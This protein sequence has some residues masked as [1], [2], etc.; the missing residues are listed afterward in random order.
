M[1]GFFKSVLATVVGL[2]LFFIIM[3]FFLVISMVGMIASGEQTKS[4]RDNSVLVL[5]LTGVMEERAENDF[6]SQL[7]GNFS[8]Q[9][10]LDDILSAIKK[11]KD[12][13][14]I[15]GIYIEAGAFA[16]DSYASMQAIRRAL[17]DFKKSGK[18]IVAYADTYTQGT[19]YLA[20]AADKVWL[21]PQGMLDWHGLAAQKV[22]FKDVLAKVGV[23]MQIAKVGSYKSAVE[24]FTGDKMSDADRE[25][26]EAYIN[27]IWQNVTKDVAAS[28][29][30]SVEQL[31]AYADSLIT[32]N[33]TKDMLKLKLVDALLYTD[34]VKTEVKKLLKIENDERI[35]QLSINDMKNVKGKSKEGE[36]IAVYYAYGDIVDGAAGGGFGNQEHQID[37]QVVCKDLQKLMDDD[38]VKAVVMRIN[39][40]G[41]S[42]YASEQI[43]HALMEMK[44]KKPVVVSMGGMAASGGYYISAPANWI[45]A[46]PTTLTGS[47]GI[48]GMFPDASELLTQK[49]GLKYDEVKTNKFSTFGAQNRPIS[50]EEMAYLEAYI[51][52]GYQL[53][54]QRVAQGRKMTTDQV[55]KIA[56]G[57]VWIGQDALGIKLVD[58]LGGLDA[59]V[60]KAASLAKLQEY[61]TNSY[62]APADWMDQLLNET[63]GGNYLDEELQAT[64]GEYYQPIMLMK[65]IRQMNPIQTRLP[66]YIYIR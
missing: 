1:K 8:G 66:Y 17:T 39:S 23:K 15:K 33:D 45:V 36:E 41:G 60:A 56:Q 59:A 35:H 11:A 25:Q 18:W 49:I 64:L 13:E 7:T 14:K 24:I 22:Y 12:N 34:Q 63:K 53:F 10:G 3:G 51:E 48:F 46:E 6:M 5:N 4:V 58:Q 26:T 42:A 47:I 2:F 29:K 21:N 9:L 27:G 54:R 31:N 19:Y 44:K 62:P 50:A 16:P 32:F 55:E 57:H 38:D 28:R 52:R 30:L 43:W 40:G 61:H 20:S 37:A 65:Q